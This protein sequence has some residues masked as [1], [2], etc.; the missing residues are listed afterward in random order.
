MLITRILSIS[1]TLFMVDASP[2]K[3]HTYSTMLAEIL[4][5]PAKYPDCVRVFDALEEWPSLAF[6][7]VCCNDALWYIAFRLMNYNVAIPVGANLW[8]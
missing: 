1:I 8:L 2:F 3:Y 4:G 5:L 6:A 7:K